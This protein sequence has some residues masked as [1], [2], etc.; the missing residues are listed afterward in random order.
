MLHARLSPSRWSTQVST[1]CGPF[2]TN[3]TLSAEELAGGAV[4][5]TTV[6]YVFGR[7]A[8]ACVLSCWCV[9]EINTLQGNRN[10][11]TAREGVM[12]CEALGLT[13]EELEKVCVCVGGGSL[14]VLGLWLTPRAEPFLT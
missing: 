5:L 4:E 3:L 11:M 9:G 1:L 14:V 8:V 13:K 6:M 2:P 7:A 12:A 10:W